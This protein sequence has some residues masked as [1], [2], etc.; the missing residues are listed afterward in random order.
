MCIRD[1]YQ[2]RVRGGNLLRMVVS[3]E[4]IDK[5]VDG[6]MDLDHDGTLTAEECM[7]FQASLSGEE[8]RS[9]DELDCDMKEMV[10]ATAAAAKEMI[11][12]MCSDEDIL[13]T[14]I[15]NYEEVH[16]QSQR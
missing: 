16:Q 2:R 3:Q 15:A 12:R 6:F 4:K 5:I 1:R 10:G 13:D 9:V 14:I 11:R 8:V 7:K